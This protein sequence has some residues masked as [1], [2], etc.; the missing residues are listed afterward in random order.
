MRS[1]VKIG[2]AKDGWSTNLV[3]NVNIDKRGILK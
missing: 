2:E 3:V 1:E